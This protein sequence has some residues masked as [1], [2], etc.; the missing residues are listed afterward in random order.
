MVSILLADPQ[1]KQKF[2]N[3]DQFNS[4]TFRINIQ[5]LI[6]DII[7][8][9]RN[10]D[11]IRK[12]WS[13]DGP[14]FD[15]DTAG[16]WFKT[17]QGYV[18]ADEKGKLVRYGV[19]DE[20]TRVLLTKNSCY[21]TALINATPEQ[22]RK[23]LYECLLEN[24][25]KGVDVC[26]N[27]RLLNRNF[28][29]VSKAEIENMHP[30]IALMTLKKFGFGIYKRY[31]EKY[32]DDLR[33]IEDIEHWKENHPK[34]IYIKKYKSGQIPTDVHNM[35][36]T[37]GSIEANRAFEKFI[38][39][40]KLLIEYLGIISDHVNSN[41]GILNAGYEG[42]FEVYRKSDEKKDKS[43]VPTED[44]LLASDYFFRNLVETRRYYDYNYDALKY[45]CLPFMIDPVTGPDLVCR[46]AS[47]LFIQR[48]SVDPTESKHSVEYLLRK[49]EEQDPITNAI[50]DAFTYKYNKALELGITISDHDNKIKEIV[51]NYLDAHKKALNV[52][53]TYE[54]YVNICGIL[55]DYPYDLLS[56]EKQRRLKAICERKEISLEKIQDEL[57]DQ[58]AEIEEAIRE[59]I[60]SK[61]QPIRNI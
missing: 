49:T 15:I 50:V 2:P 20:V 54:H 51:D 53:E 41:P 26:L 16:I 30:L 18:K 39:E 28:Y 27:M 22:C 56:E 11:T 58:G 13:Y 61:M 8:A 14:I 19:N 7:N 29:E 52:L 42:Y 3:V 48:K 37:G 31:V 34:E 4:P 24:D 10:P 46:T 60:A 57:L 5:K 45:R 23:Y 38:E 25:D 55:K 47:G 6:R 35:I 32:D 12:Y 33:F 43:K 40:N 59:S 1:S 17:N 44:E 21:S 9:V 36:L